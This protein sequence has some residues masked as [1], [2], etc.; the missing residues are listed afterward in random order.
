MTFLGA[1][2]FL[3]S[4]GLGALPAWLGSLPDVPRRAV[5]VPTAANPLPSA[6]FVRA[7]AEMLRGEG[8]AVDVF[9]LEGA[10]GDGVRRVLDGVQVV[11]VTGGI[12]SSCWSMFVAAGVDR[13]AVP[14]VGDG[15]LAYVGIS[16]GA[17]LAGPDLRRCEV[18]TIPGRSTPPPGSAWSRSSCCRTGTG[19]GP[20]GTTGWPASPDGRGP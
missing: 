13:V 15:S 12:R 9:D 16:A 7:A 2:L 8:L 19:D 10:S 5:L 18:P 1:R 4:A 11:F 17:A 6:P 14:S 20:R 3:G